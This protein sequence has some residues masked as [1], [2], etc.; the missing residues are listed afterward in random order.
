M[1]LT[2]QDAL[3][4]YFAGHGFQMKGENYLAAIDCPIEHGNEYSC[5]RNSIRLTEITEILKTAKTSVN[6]IIID[7]CRVS[8]GRGIS[9]HFTNVNAPEGT[10]IAFSTSPGESASDSGEFG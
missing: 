2:D 8:I 5:G 10:I 7:A 3:L 1:K 4:I 6:I 9:T